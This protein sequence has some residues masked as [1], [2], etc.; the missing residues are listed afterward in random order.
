VPTLD[1]D[2]LLAP[3][4]AAAAELVRFGALAMAADVNLPSVELG[5]T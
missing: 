4:I 1:H 2:R 5:A 3:D